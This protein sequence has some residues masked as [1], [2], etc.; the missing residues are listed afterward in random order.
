MQGLR[1]AA[2][3]LDVFLD[4]MSLRPGVDWERELMRQIESR[5]VMYLFW[6]EAA[7]QS[8]W[9]EREWRYAL[10]KRGLEFIDPFPLEDVSAVPPPPELARLH[11]SDPIL[12]LS[13]ATFRRAE[14]GTENVFRETGHCRVALGG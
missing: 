4:R 14:T 8:E 9:V 13:V 12:I 7:R 11:F 2:P 1:K 6:S 5:D 3:D 10:E